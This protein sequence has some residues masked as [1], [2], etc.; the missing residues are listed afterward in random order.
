MPGSCFVRMLILGTLVVAPAWALEGGDG[1]RAGYLTGTLR[2]TDGTVMPDVRFRVELVSEA[3]GEVVAATE[4]V[5]VT[6]QYALREPGPGRYRVQA[7]AMLEPQAPEVRFVMTAVGGGD[8]RLDA[9]RAAL[10]DFRLERPVLYR[11]EH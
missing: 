9:G 7:I 3:T 2:W 5:D 6:G 4:D 8:I 1:A 10:K 11:T